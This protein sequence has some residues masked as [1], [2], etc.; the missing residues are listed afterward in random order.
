[1][2]LFQSNKKKQMER[3]I[4][5]YKQSIQRR[6]NLSIQ[7][8]DIDKVNKAR[9]SKT[10]LNEDCFS[11]KFPSSSLSVKS[12]NINKNTGRSNQQSQK[13]LHLQKQLELEKQRNINL[14]NKI[15]VYK[16][17]YN[18]LVSKLNNN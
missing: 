4:E 17:R 6:E 16:T 3:K 10:N 11:S 2:N 18:E 14:E 7:N 5:A 8:D 12:G 9:K 1:M 13:Q 15:V